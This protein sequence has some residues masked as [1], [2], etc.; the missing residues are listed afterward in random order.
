MKALP[1]SLVFSLVCLSAIRA[2]NSMEKAVSPAIKV[3]TFDVDATPPL[4][5]AMAYGPVRR[6]DELTLRCRGIV[7]LG[8]GKPIVLC[9]VDWIGIANEGHDQFREMLAHAAGTTRERVAVH[10]LHQHDAPSCDFTAERLIR[11]LGLKDFGR[12]DSGFQREVMQR[13]ARAVKRALASAQPATHY[14]WGSAQVKEVASNRRILGP[15][16]K[17]RA[18]RYT[19]TRDPALRAEPEGVID[20]EVSLLS[21][22]NENRPIA[23]LTYYACH[24]QSYYRTG[25]PN[26]DFPG[27]ARFIRGQAVPEALH[28]HFDGAGGNIGAG[29]YNDGSPENRMVL[30]QRLADGMKQAFAEVK[31]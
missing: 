19:A 12:F 29:K 28:V 24:P 3:A 5:S 11:D 20:P 18:V 30:A 17:V 27:I 25:V 14:G 6:L 23:V 21:F 2:G 13:A 8:A 16:G 7:I 22:W 10:T 4:G 1:L 31:K 9:A 15:D 26:P